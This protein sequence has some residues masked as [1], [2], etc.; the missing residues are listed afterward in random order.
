[1][2]ASMKYWSPLLNI[3]KISVGF[4]LI[5]HTWLDKGKLPFI[6]TTIS[7]LTHLHPRPLF[8]TVC[9]SFSF[10]LISSIW[11]E[12]VWKR[13]ELFLQ[14]LLRNCIKMGEDN[15]EPTLFHHLLIPYNL[16]IL[17]LSTDLSG[18]YAS[19]LRYVHHVPSSCN[20]MLTH[21]YQRKSDPHCRLGGSIRCLLDTPLANKD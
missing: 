9:F 7:P 4:N 11:N 19:L 13:H 20:V 16:N 3:F 17:S 6:E 1:M 18:R 8:V 2:K 5:Q 15:I 21:F 14:S 12:I 10:L